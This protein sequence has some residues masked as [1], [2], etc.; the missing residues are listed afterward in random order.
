MLFRVIDIETTGVGDD[1]EICEVGFCD[2]WRSD[3]GGDVAIQGGGSCLVRTSRPMPPEAQAVHHI[4]DADLAEYGVSFPEAWAYMLHWQYGGADE[5]TK[6]AAPHTAVSAYVAHNAGFEQR[7]VKKQW[8]GEAP[9][10]CTF[11][12]AMRA[13]PDLPAF[14]NQV[15]RY[16]LRLPIMNHA[17]TLPVHAAA[18]DAYI[19]AHILER[20]LIE[21]SPAILV[22]WSK[23]PALYPRMMMGK[24]KG[25]TWA[26]LPTHHLKWMI[27]HSS[28]ANDTAWQ[29]WQY[30]ARLELQRRREARATRVTSKAVR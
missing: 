21:Y 25:L 26:E 10:I 23:E 20:L 9:W 3:K 15:L 27:E 18:P 22:Q 24:Y 19:T 17:R 6:D 2:A 28:E 14:G 11:K 5:R 8:T 12:C 7:F 4:S 13:W 30:G 1:D 16:A 29:D